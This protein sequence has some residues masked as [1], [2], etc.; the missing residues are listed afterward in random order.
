VGDLTGLNALLREE[1]TPDG[2]NGWFE[3]TAPLGRASAFVGDVARALRLNRTPGLR[4]RHA[5]I[6][7]S[8]NS[9][10]ANVPA[11]L[12]VA[13]VR[14]RLWPVEHGLAYA[15]RNP[16]REERAAALT[17]LIP[18][19]GCDRAATQA[20]ALQGAAAIRD[21]YR[22]SSALAA[23]APHLP[24]NLLPKALEIAM[25]FGEEGLRASALA[26]LTPYLNAD[27]LAR[28]LE[29]AANDDKASDAGP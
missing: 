8:L 27:L 21:D 11:T 7:A 14:H 15:R 5:L 3:A 4:C 12:I 9:R 17:G 23:L 16:S 22:R 29:T 19:V 6:L 18:H 13:V 25:T 24:A 1:E 2:R 26:D 20:H 28:A 10:A